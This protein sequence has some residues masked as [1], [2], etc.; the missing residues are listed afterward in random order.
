MRHRVDGKT[1]GRR[2]EGRRALLRGLA[3][4]LLEVGRIETTI[5]KAK[6]LRRV[7]EP[8]VTLAKRGDLHARRQ[9]AGYLYTKRDKEKNRDKPVAL[10][11]LFGEIA[12]RFRDRKGGYTRIFRTGRRQG[13]GAELALIELISGEK[14]KA[15]PKGKGKAAAAKSEKPAKKKAETSK[16]AP[17]KAKKEAPKAAKKTAKNA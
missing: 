4:S 2:P 8:L 6:E 15:E 14:K 7:V 17:A 13:D 1:F 5:T 3:T 9:A 10:L 16:E 11:N 12:E